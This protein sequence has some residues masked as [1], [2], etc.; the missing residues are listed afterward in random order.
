MEL[1][2]LTIGQSDYNGTFQLMGPNDWY[3]SLQPMGLNDY[4]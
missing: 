2:S 4:C 1:F 3:G